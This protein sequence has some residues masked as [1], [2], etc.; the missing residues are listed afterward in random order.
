LSPLVVEHGQ[1][2]ANAIDRPSTLVPGPFIFSPGA[3]A[4][5][6]RLFQQKGGRNHCIYDIILNI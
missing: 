2:D 4:W 1:V 5:L 3:C 6:T